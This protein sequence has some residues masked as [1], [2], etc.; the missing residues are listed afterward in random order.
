MLAQS[1]VVTSDNAADFK[2]RYANPSRLAFDPRLMSKTWTQDWDPMSQLTPMD[3]SQYWSLVKPKPSSY[4]FP[5]AYLQQMKAGGFG[6][7]A[8]LYADHLKIQMDDF[9]YTGVAV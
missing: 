7:V 9:S 6:K 2:K 1:I 3:I 8:K 4:Q 5:A